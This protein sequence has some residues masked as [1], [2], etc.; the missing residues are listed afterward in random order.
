MA[1][2][3]RPPRGQEKDSEHKFALFLLTKEKKAKIQELSNRTG[4]SISQLMIFA[5]LKAL[6]MNIT[7][8]ESEYETLQVRLPGHVHRQLRVK[9]EQTKIPMTDLMLLGLDE[10]LKRN[11]L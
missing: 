3:G 1:R 8:D 4:M 11:G 2:I 10:E 7:G 5:A 9:S 6:L